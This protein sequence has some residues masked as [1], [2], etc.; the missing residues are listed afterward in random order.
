MSSA[1]PL[2]RFRPNPRDTAF[3]FDLDGTLIEIAALP[4]DVAPAP[5]LLPALKRLSGLSGGAVAVVSGRRIAFLERILPG[6][7]APMAGVH[8]LELRLGAEGAAVLAEPGGGEGLTELR[9]ALGPW[10]KAHPGLT[11]EDKGLAVALHY[12]ARPDLQAEVDAFAT[13]AAAAPGA[14]LVIQRGKMV[15]ELRAAGPRKGDAL[16]AIMALPAFA[17][18]RPL[19]F[20]DDVTDEH[21][22]AAAAAMGGGG[23]FV[24][25]PTQATLAESRLDAPADVLAFIEAVARDAPQHRAGDVAEA[26]HWL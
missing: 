17:G 20:G 3:L 13:A 16:Q 24:G 21:A 18:R 7:D 19:Y 14:G 6:L 23:V 11:V 26:D 8:G 9:K 10:L 1:D 15:V 2:T 22:F 25:P 4:E 12:R 5:G